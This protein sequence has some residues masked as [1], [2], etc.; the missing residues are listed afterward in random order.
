V[1]R[2]TRAALLLALV[3][4]CDAERKCA[5]VAF[6]AGGPRSLVAAVAESLWVDTGTGPR[7]CF[8]LDTHP[9]TEAIDQ[10]DAEVALAERLVADR[11]VV[12][13]VG[14]LR[15]RGS[16][17]AAPVYRRAGL[18]QV[19]PGSTSR[20]LRMEGPW[21]F[22]LA[23]DDSAQAHFLAAAADSIGARRVLLFYSGEPYGES[24]VQSI[25]PALAARG[26][27]VADEVRLGMGTD[28]PTLTEAAVRR[29]PADAVILLTDAGQAGEIARTIVPL[30]P[31]LPLLAGDGAMY[32]TGLRNSGGVAAESLWIVS[33]WRP[34]TGD[35][36][37]RRFVERFRAAAGRDPLP[38]EAFGY[39]A[40]LFAAAAIEAVG[41][42]R[43]AIRAW[44]AG[45]GGALSP[46]GHVT[47]A[48]L[49]DGPPP[50]FHFARIGPPPT[51]RP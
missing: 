36:T 8:R 5:T 23:P 29:R 27:A 12:A 11:S 19:V 43:S 40:L 26:V 14:H 37:V 16:L 2:R 32:P 9:T 33:L 30:R 44:L 42:D 47:L 6:A 41:A 50:T 28:V 35:A 18:P 21:T 24:L 1:R 46:R 51:P 39:D 38:G 34:D 22:V 15:S 45:P 3:A 20:L 4:G 48:T 7:A 25:R 10:P 13:V 31:R 49:H 17:A